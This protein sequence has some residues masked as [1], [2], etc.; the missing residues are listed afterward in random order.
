[1]SFKVFQ[2][3]ISKQFES[4]SGQE[5]FYTDVSRDEIWDTYLHSY[6]EGSNPMFKERTEHDCNCCK[7]FIRTCGSV[8]KV[9]QDGSRSSIW[10]V[11]IGGYPVYQ[12]VAD[13]MSA[14]VKSKPIVNVFK[15]YER[16]LGRVAHHVVLKDGTTTKFF[17]FHH[18][19]PS[20]QV[21]AKDKIDSYKGL[22]TANKQVLER[23]VKEIT[24]ESVDVVLDLIGQNS[25]YRG[26]E[27]KSILTLL[28]Q[29]KREYKTADNKDSY[30]WLK[31]IS[32]GGAAKIRNTVIGTL[33]TDISEGVDLEVAV[34]SFETKVAPTN[35]KRPT[36]LV[37]K[38]MIDKAEKMVAE[39]GIEESLYRRYA[40]AED[41]TINN[42]LFADRSL[43]KVMGVFDDLKGTAK[44]KQPDLSKVQEIG[45][46]EFIANVVPN[47]SSIELYLENSHVNNLVSLIAPVHPEAKGIFKWGNNF[48]WS[49]NGEVTDSIK[50]RVKA[51]GGSVTGD[52][53]ASLSWYN[54]DDLDLHALT[55][56][57]EHIYFCAR[58][59]AKTKGK[60]DVDMN[61]GGRYSREPVENITWDKKETLTEG[62]YK[63]Y[64]N[65]YSQRESK[66]VGFEL[67]LEFMGTVWNFVYDKVVKG[68]VPVVEFKYSK[69]DGIQI[70]SS[71]PSTTKSK[72]AWGV[73]TC[74]Y[75]KVST[76]MH[77]PNHWDGEQTGNKHWFF[78]LEGC[79]NPDS[80]RGFYN[81][82]LSNDLMEHRK[83]FELL[84]SKLKAPYSDKQ[85][86][87]VGFSSTKQ[88]S[89]LCKVGGTFNRTVKIKF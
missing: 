78:M 44:E 16:S 43:K 63:I 32:L 17:H 86:S 52:L 76:I 50:E 75:R 83:V 14:L 39:L 45:I 1:M 41:I 57:N 81:E 9:N 89:V 5:L 7:Q 64:V 42:V 28:K 88:A 62:V 79:T 72:Q 87:G 18:T 84:G 2:E 66:D 26:E 11:T 6:P 23:S 36:A 46:D 30:L 82:F 80:S 70:I 77:S 24:D 59:G 19:L 3:A 56:S 31:S 48:S 4:L 37:T 61:A 35:Y 29:L 8:V 65:Q 12:A 60:L 34:K 22:N 68:N 74:A 33:L 55:P 69:K 15:H 67:E 49:Y 10:D 13:A 54:H 71:L 25:L 58:I 53:R 85:L 51:A 38:G 20:L 27:H 21:M 47:A 73:D 40:V